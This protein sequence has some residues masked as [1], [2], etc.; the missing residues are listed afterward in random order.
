M[1]QSFNSL[2]SK[3]SIF[4]QE[5]NKITGNAF[6]RLFNLHEYQSKM[7]MKK[8]DVSIEKF[9]VAD[10]PDE[11]ANAFKDLGLDKVAV[12]SQVH[13]GGRGKGHFIENNFQGGIRF[14]KSAEEVKDCAKNM[15]GFHLR[16][17]QSGPEGKL[18]KKLMIAEMKNIKREL[19]FAIL[20]DRKTQG[21]VIVVSPKGGVDIEEVAESSP[22]YIAKFPIDIKTGPTQKQKE[23][24]A[25]FLE[26]PRYAWP[27]I[28]R[29]V[30]KLYNLFTKTDST[31]VEINPLVETNEGQVVALDAKFN[32]DDSA[33][34][35][36]KDIFA[37]K[38]DSE[39]DPRELAAKKYDL[40]YVPMDGNIGC[41][42]NGAGLAMATM[43]IIKLN[44]ENP[45]N[46][47]DVGGG[48]E[49]EQI[50]EAFKIISSDPQ[51]KAILVN[52]FGGIMK[53][54]VIAKGIV[55]AVKILGLKVPL[56]VRLE[57]TNVDL[58]KQIFKESGLPIIPANDLGEAAKKACEAV[59]RK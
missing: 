23:E 27:D 7:L 59:R 52:I 20:L 19:Y 12:K 4:K 3:R 13:T 41:M 31:L 37:W 2:K 58:G 30:D 36:Q 24:I 47:L 39:T 49:E 45:A 9:R 14:C 34:Y 22:Q 33:E 44:G 43:D 54:D 38:D 17:K 11:A 15:I 18:C 40:S 48:A 28:I 16:T 42:V 25:Q 1:L 56:V 35:R 57:G 51:V 10:T 26:F 55:N 6:K 50:V 8:Y 46:F 5:A 21:P 29:E 32:F 53:C